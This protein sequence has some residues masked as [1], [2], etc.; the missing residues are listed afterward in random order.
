[1]SS[2]IDAST[3][4][5][6]GIITTADASGNLNLQSGGNTV[7]AV[8]SAGAAVTGTLS[9]TGVSTFPAGTALLP[10]ITTTGDTN[11][12]VWFPAADTV[13]VSTSGAEAMRIDSSGNVGVGTSSPG[14]KLEVAGNM[15]INTGGNPSMTVKTS[16]A[17]NNP[18]YRLQADINFWDLQATFSNAND[19]LFFM[20]NSSTKMAIDS[21]GRVTMPYQPLVSLSQYRTDVGPLTHRKMVW[22]TPTINT[23]GHWNN[24]THRFT[25]PVSGIYQIVM[26]G[27]KYPQYG[28]SH[29][30]L[31]KNG[32]HV[33]PRAR[34]EEA[35]IYA[36]FSITEFINAAAG[37]YFEFYHFGDAGLH[38]GHGSYSIKLS[39]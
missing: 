39:N 28:A 22:F 10:A 17:G 23:G 37:D 9:A 3:T 32:L 19:E 20:Y 38:G 29:V 2:T 18:S 5:V 7:V 8:T 1:M 24:T 36:Q 34:A 15:L 6:G 12:G 13:A 27:I 14:Q 33:G 35:P 4:G 26:Q 11:T 16:G 25:C 31:H 30:D 21:A